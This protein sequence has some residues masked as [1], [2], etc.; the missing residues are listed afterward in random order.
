MVFDQPGI[1]RGSVDIPSKLEVKSTLLTSAEQTIVGKDLM[2]G[3]GG[4]DSF[5]E[6]RE[7]TAGFCGEGEPVGIHTNISPE[8]KSGVRGLM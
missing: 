7:A 4:G 3:A 2:E 5:P 8:R 6:I 1:F